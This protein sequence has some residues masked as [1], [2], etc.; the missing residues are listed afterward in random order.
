MAVTAFD[1][2]EHT[3]RL[4][5]RRHAHSDHTIIIGAKEDKLAVKVLLAG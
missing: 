2:G 5:A 4:I 1:A 3:A